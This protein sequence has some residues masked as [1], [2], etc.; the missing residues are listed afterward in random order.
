ML[1]CPRAGMQGVP[2]GSEGSAPH[3]AARLAASHP[4][5][6]RE[7]DRQ[8]LLVN[9]LIKHLSPHPKLAKHHKAHFL[10]EAFLSPV[11]ATWPS[12]SVTVEF[13]C[14]GA[15]PQGSPSANQPFSNLGEQEPM[16]GASSE[17]SAECA[18]W[19]RHLGAGRRNPFGPP[20][21]GAS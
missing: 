8:T 14:A 11:P 3:D 9:K 4:G 5:K 10:P 20:G 12:E 15:C 16:Q 6:G 7:A 13:S 19:G 2:P 1:K 17:A 21:A 18:A